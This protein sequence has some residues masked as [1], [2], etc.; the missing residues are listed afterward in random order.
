MTASWPKVGPPRLVVLA[1]GASSRLGQPKALAALPGGAPLDRI[2]GAWPNKDLPAWVVTGCHHAEI[3]EAVLRGHPQEQILHNPNWAL[4]RTGSLQVA[5]GHLP[6][7]D[8][9]IAPVDC[10]R[11]PRRVFEALLS[12]WNA[13]DSPAFGWCAPFLLDADTG[14]NCYG[15]PILIGR[16]L[17]ARA[18]NMGP[19]M[20]LRAL[21]S[22]AQPLLGVQVQDREILEDLDTPEDLEK[23]MR[24]DWQSP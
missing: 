21:R 16:G 12:H 3:S 20:P 1:A 7:Q 22:D 9:L 8:L 15:H 11:P 10:P 18:L 4:G 23:L 6:G 24:G 19:D 2:L 13:A 14:K 5:I 17:A